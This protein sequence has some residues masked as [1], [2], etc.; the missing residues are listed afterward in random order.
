MTKQE[1]KEA[2][3]L[4]RAKWFAL[5]ELKEAAARHGGSLS[6]ND[7]DAEHKLGNLRPRRWY[8]ENFDP[9]RGS[10]IPALIHAGVPLKKSSD[11]KREWWAC[12]TW[13]DKRVRERLI[14]VS[15]VRLLR[16][17]T[18]YWAEDRGYIPPVKWL[19]KQAGDGVTVDKL[20]AMILKK[21]GIVEGTRKRARR[22]ATAKRTGL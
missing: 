22:A 6:R 10:H 7:M 17:S 13:D 3:E 8:V 18:L 16:V 19:R 15:R 12:V 2:R 20:P 4:K 1:K 9:N 5:R 21:Y 14:M 11:G